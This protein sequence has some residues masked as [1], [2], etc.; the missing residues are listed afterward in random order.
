MI[1]LDLPNINTGGTVEEQ[2][3]E[4]RSYIYKNNEQMNATL[5]N[6]TT[7]KFW[8]NTASAISSAENKSETPQLLSQYAK[9][10]DLI[11]KTATEVSKTDEHYN[12]LL[13]GGYLAKSQFGEYL[14]NTSVEVDGKSTGFTEVYHY[15][16]QINSLGNSFSEYRLDE[17]MYIKRGLLDDSGGDPIYG[18][19]LGILNKKVVVDGETH[20]FDTAYR[21]RITPDKWSFIYNGLAGENK[22]VAYIQA[23]KIYFPNADITGGSININDKFIVNSLGEMTA[24]SGTFSGTLAVASLE[25]AFNTWGSQKIKLDSQSIV[26]KSDGENDFVIKPGGIEFYKRDS[27]DR[28]MAEI[29]RRKIA[30]TSHC[31]LNIRMDKNYASFFLITD[32]SNNND[33]NPV[34]AYIPEGIMPSIDGNF[35][36][37]VHGLHINTTT[38]FHGNNVDNVVINSMN[39]NGELKADGATGVTG[40]TIVKV[41]VKK[42]DGTYTE[43]FSDLYIHDGIITGIT[44]LTPI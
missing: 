12:M 21:T 42:S 13:S 22:E 11:I 17:S 34:F 25:S 38:D 6:L 15:G 7:E 14:L 36:N 27:V 5:A 28:V 39:I 4:I 8:E 40:R 41:A 37:G 33:E 44:P 3:S 31:G 19:E 10:R 32:F 23:D 1:Y 2:L 9:V 24:Q 26:F 18:I 30:R 16:A 20:Q 43:S 35:F 29:R